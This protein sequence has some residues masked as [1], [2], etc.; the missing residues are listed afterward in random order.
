V[1]FELDPVKIIKCKVCGTDVVVNA[2]YPITEVT[3]RPCHSLKKE[4]K[5]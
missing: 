3:C 4:S 1:D 2:R 5:E